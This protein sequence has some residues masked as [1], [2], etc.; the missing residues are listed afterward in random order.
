MRRVAHTVRDRL[1]DT[2]NSGATRAVDNTPARRLAFESMERC[3]KPLVLV[4]LAVLTMSATRAV[5]DDSAT[6]PLGSPF[7]SSS[8][9]PSTTSSTG[10]YSPAVPVSEL[11]RPSGF[12]DP[13]RFKM[14]TEISFGT[15]Y[16]GGT[17]GLQLMHFGYQFSAPLAMRV[18]V[19][20]AFGPTTMQS[21]HPFLEGLDL[22]YR[23][24]RSMMINVQYR[25]IRSPLQLSGYGYGLDPVSA[26]P[27]Y[28]G[29]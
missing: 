16:G 4:A 17:S 14:S 15:T 22:A 27:G 26:W 1:D 12:L 8:S 7:S 20:N 10:G 11:A 29:H 24:F 23:P 2:L 3:L 18:S 21:N 13:S 25:D 6:S 28:F 5:A 19:G 9:S